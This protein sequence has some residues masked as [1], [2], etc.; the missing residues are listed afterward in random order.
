MGRVGEN[1]VFSCA[2]P[3]F[4]ISYLDNALVYQSLEFLEKF[5]ILLAQCQTFSRKSSRCYFQTTLFLHRL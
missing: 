1:Y 4:S 2:I 5:L 3:R